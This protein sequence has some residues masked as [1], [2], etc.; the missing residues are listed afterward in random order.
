MSTM[1]TGDPPFL[2]RTTAPD[3]WFGATVLSSE[4]SATVRILH[5]KCVK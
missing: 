2:G 4:G 3:G 5:E 1:S